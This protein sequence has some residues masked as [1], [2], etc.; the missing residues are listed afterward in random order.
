MIA[1]LYVDPRGQAGGKMKLA[2]FGIWEAEI[3]VVSCIAVAG[4]V[5]IALLGCGLV[6]LLNMAIRRP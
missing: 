6:H 5:L 1:A 4:F 2:Q 3:F